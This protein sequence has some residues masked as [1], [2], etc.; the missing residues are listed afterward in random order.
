L[1]PRRIE[2]IAADQRPA[3]Q[4]VADNIEI[5]SENVRAL[6]T[7]E[8]KGRKGRR[9]SAG[10]D[11]ELKTAVRQQVENRGVLR[12]PHRTFQRQ[13]DDA[14]PKPNAGRLRSDE[15]EKSE[16]SGKPALT[17]MKMVLRNPCRIKTCAFRVPDLLCRQ[18]IP[19][20]R[21]RVVEK[22]RKKA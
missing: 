1:R 7:I 3:S 11:T 20:R 5:P 22:P 8:S 12:H 19:L 9:I 18:P 14:G 10:P 17:L 13:R 16:R 2:R 4:G 6:G 21:S 15:T